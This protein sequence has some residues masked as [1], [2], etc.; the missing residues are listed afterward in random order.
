MSKE[1]SY[2]NIVSKTHTKLIP[3]RKGDAIY[4]ASGI[5]PNRGIDADIRSVLGIK[6]EIPYKEKSKTLKIYQIF[7]DKS[8][9]ERCF[10]SSVITPLSLVPNFKS[11]RKLFE[12][13]G[14]IAYTTN[15]ISESRAVLH[16][17]RYNEGHRFIGFTSHKHDLKFYRMDRSVALSEIDESL[18]SKCLSDSRVK[19]ISFR[20]H[21]CFDFIS[22]V[23]I[24]SGRGAEFIISNFLKDYYRFDDKAFQNL[25]EEMNGKLFP[26]C[27]CYIGRRE[28]VQGYGEFLLDFLTWADNRYGLDRTQIR[29]ER[30]RRSYCNNR[31]WGYI[32]EQLPWYYLALRYG[33]N[34]LLAFIDKN[35]VISFHDR[36][37]YG[38]IG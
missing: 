34:F 35:K 17:C 12:Q 10:D 37:G 6:K 33:K 38:L 26:Y 11:E 28:E 2:E 19:F 32:C 27:N 36:I 15:Q 4:R 18:V 23:K 25:K 20:I 29:V 16:A 31:G 21:P 24:H 22:S 9:F 14:D 30:E 5:L 7:H 1:V 3:N 8:S 13:L